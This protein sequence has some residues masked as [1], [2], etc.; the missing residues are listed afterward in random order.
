MQ[1]KDRMAR[2]RM[3]EAERQEESDTRK[4]ESKNQDR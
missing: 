1:K 2:E 3:G 4:K